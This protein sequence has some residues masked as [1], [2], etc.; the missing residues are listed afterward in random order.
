MIAAD[1]G[2]TNPEAG[3]TV[4]NSAIDPEAS[5]KVVGLPFTNHSAKTQ[6]NAAAPVAIC[7]ATNANVG[8][9]FA[10]SAAPALNPSRPSHS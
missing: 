1:V 4:T 10:A 7:V 8:V 6:D 3:V 2:P 5:P 9:L